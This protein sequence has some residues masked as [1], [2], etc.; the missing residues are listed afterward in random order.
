MAMVFE[1]TLGNAITVLALLVMG[2]W[3]MAKV[4]ARIY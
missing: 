3:A 1:V 4:I 2:A